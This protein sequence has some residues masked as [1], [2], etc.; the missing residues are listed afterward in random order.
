MHR[1]MLRP[2]Q[3]H[4]VVLFGSGVAQARPPGLHSP[5]TH[6][7]CG[8]V[9]LFHRL[10]GARCVVILYRSGP[11]ASPFATLTPRWTRD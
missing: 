6:S 11:F 4:A 1:H 9:C 10:W 3:L 8:H 7:L 2:A 5:D